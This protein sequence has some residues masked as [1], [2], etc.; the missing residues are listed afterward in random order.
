MV[1]RLLLAT[2]THT[3]HYIRT[4]N[5]ITLSCGFQRFHIAL[6]VPSYAEGWPSDFASSSSGASPLLL[7][8]LLQ[9]FG[10]PCLYLRFLFEGI[11]WRLFG[12]YQK[13]GD[14][15][16]IRLKYA[17]SPSAKAWDMALS[18][19]VFALLLIFRHSLGFIGSIP[20]SQNNNQSQKFWHML[21]AM[22]C[23]AASN[24]F[25]EW[26]ANGV[27][28]A[29]MTTSPGDAMSSVALSTRRLSKITLG[30]CMRSY[31][32]RRYLGSGGVVLHTI[33]EHTKFRCI[34]P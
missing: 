3:P 6:L 14:L 17:H 15:H 29:C 7:C 2:P 4:H 13:I 16:G 25:M 21:L 10:T 26:N 32:A 1:S 22:R 8:R 34:V 27:F 30:W 33:E 23:G 20:F 18:I 24:A 31:S 12:A 19:P 11:T 9:N 5:C 28:S